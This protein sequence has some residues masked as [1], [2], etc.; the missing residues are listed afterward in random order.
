M[1]Y[2]RYSDG[3]PSEIGFLKFME[4]IKNDVSKYRKSNPRVYEIPFNPDNKYQ[5]TVH[6]TKMFDDKDRFLVVMIGAPEIVI[7]KCNCYLVN[8][9]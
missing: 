9:N 8:G 4:Q 1:N 7:S 2:F 6:K 5:V 3:N